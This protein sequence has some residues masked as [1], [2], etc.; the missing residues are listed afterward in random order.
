MGQRRRARHGAG[1]AASG[2]ASAAALVVVVAAGCSAPALDDEPHPLPDLAAARPDDAPPLRYDHYTGD[3]WIAG[4]YFVRA[5]RWRHPATGQAVLLLPMIHLGDAAFYAEAGEL[6]RGADVVL[7]EGVGGAPSLSPTSLLL[8]WIF[9]NYARGCWLGDLVPQGDALREGPRA[10]PGDLAEAE[11]TAEA[12]C[13][14]PL[15]HAVA[16]PALV[17]LVEPIHLGRWLLGAGRRAAGAGAQDG[18]A[19]RHFLVESTG[20]AADPARDDGDGEGFLPG[21]IE[22]RNEHLL[23]R[24]DEVLARAGVVEIALPWGARHLDGLAAGLRE[25]GFAPEWQRWLRAVAVRARLL[26]PELDVDGGRFHAYV[27]YLFDVQRYEATWSA[28]VACD[29]V[30]LHRRRAGFE[31]ALLW[32]FLLNL[33]L[34]SERGESGFSLLP[35]LFGRPLLFD[36]RRRGDLHRVRCLWFLEFGG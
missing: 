11:F 7:S 24:L 20:D 32:G 25:R 28:G 10:E 33:E 18:A 22:R 14:T 6:L 21:V 13:T 30:L 19:L 12:A 35:S 26:D 23:A 2:T 27:P 31:A 34:G 36:W 8:R 29:A 17:L 3:E 1:I 16:L 9:G 5:E 15:L 4:D